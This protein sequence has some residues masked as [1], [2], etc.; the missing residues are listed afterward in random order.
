MP[1][2]EKQMLDLAS[3]AFLEPKSRHWLKANVPGCIHT[4]LGRHN[5]IPIPSLDRTTV[6]RGMRFS[7][8][9]APVP[10]ASFANAVVVL[11]P[12]SALL[13]GIVYL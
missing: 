1:R 9:S 10:V 3:W 2:M 6:D 4:D 8:D 7:A 13:G 12:A 11:V 5:L